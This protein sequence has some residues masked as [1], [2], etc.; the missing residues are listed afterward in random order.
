M[1][2]T[3]DGTQIFAARNLAM[4]QSSFLNVDDGTAEMGVNGTP[5]GDPTVVWNGT[6]VSDTGGDWEHEAQGTETAESMKS[7]TNGMDSGVRPVGQATRFDY[8][9]N[10]DIASLYS[11]LRFWVQPKAFP[12]GAR[13]DIQWKTSGGAT[14]GAKLNIADYIS[15]YDLDEWQQVQIPVADF[16]LGA[17]VAK[18]ELIY[19]SQGGQHFWFDDFELLGS[20]GGPYTFRIEA[21][22]AATQYHVSSLMLLLV[23]ENGTWNADMFASLS[24]LTNG[25]LIKHVDRTNPLEPVTLWSINFKTNADLF[26]RLVVTNNIEFY[27]DEHLFMFELHSE[28][29][30]ITVTDT[31]VLE[32]SVQDNL[33]AINTLR[34]FAQYGVENL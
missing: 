33:Q 26:G 7:G 8:G 28:I 24:G 14:P 25:L 11:I 13:L 20:G 34:A 19:A 27:N 3:S 29:A 30:S 10:Q 2:R 17:D 18:L 9:S 5:S 1:P 16:A 23:E 31:K 22:D 21:P 15:D 12:V 6:G 32:I 4:G